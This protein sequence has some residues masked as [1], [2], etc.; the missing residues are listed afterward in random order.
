MER[1]ADLFARLG[2]RGTSVSD[3]AEACKTSKSLFYHYYPSKEDVLFAVMSSHID[4]LVADVEAVERLDEQPGKKLALLV[5]AFMQHYVGATNRQK[6]LLNELGNLPPDKQS[7][8]V[9]QQRKII[10]AVRDLLIQ[11]KPSLASDLPR[12]RVEAMLL[13]GMLN[14]T[15]TWFDP[16]GTISADTVAD[17]VLERIQPDLA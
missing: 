17:M 5:H 7:T 1:A 9:S 8:I 13:F 2:F 6:V 16:A 12:A 11:I 10:D 14:W 4:I 15:H 3:L